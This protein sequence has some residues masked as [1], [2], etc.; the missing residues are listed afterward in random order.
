MNI[1]ENL[2]V[3]IDSELVD[4]IPN[5]I[6]NRKIEIQEVFNSIS[7]ENFIRLKEIGHNMRGVSGAFGYDFIVE[8]GGK[9][10]F[11]A[12]NKDINALMKL[13]QI[14]QIQFASHLI[15]IEG[16]DKTYRPCE[17]SKT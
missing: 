6:E 16:D 14:Y 15:E 11:A 4:L 12:I 5:F 2:K 10:E 3:L 1:D 17:F 8:I 9:I 7:D 13:A